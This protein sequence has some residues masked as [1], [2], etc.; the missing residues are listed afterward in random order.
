MIR[1][2][3]YILL[4]P[5]LLLIVLHT[6]IPHAFSNALPASSHLKIHK[7]SHSLLGFFGLIFH[8]K[9]EKSLHDLNSIRINENPGFS[10][11]FPVSIFLIEEIA[12][13]FID[14][15]YVSTFNNQ[16][17]HFNLPDV[18]NLTSWRGPPCY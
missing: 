17:F 3:K 2:L 5:V 18:L 9:H 13:D 10:K 16:S 6:F 1:F 11:L 4:Y 8:E 15:L 14:F 7:E 12:F